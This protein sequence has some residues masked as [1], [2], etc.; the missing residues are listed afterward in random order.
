MISFESN[1]VQVHI[2]AYDESINDYK[3]LIIQRAETKH[4]YPGVWQV[5]S[6]TIE[7][8]EKAIETAIREIN[9]EIGIDI[10]KNCLWTLPYTA[11][12]FNPYQD[13]MQFSPVFG[14]IIDLNSKIKL[15]DEHQNYQWVNYWHL[16]DF[17]IIPSHC[18]ATE[19]FKKY[20]LNNPQNHFYKFKSSSK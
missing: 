18:L 20:I 13:I 19:I 10:D 14:A 16:I 8:N 5:I 6:G 12:F 7:N 11:S 4:P 1:S 9:E 2:A 3:Y 17:L 15:S